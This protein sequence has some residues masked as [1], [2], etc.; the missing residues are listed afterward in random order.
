MRYFLAKDNDSHWYVVPCDRQAEWDAWCTIVD[1]DERGWT[2]PDFVQ[3]VGG[4]PSRV[5]FTDPRID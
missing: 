5:T 2:P 4:A 1:G 3:R